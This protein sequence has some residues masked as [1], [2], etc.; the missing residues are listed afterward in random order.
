MELWLPPVILPIFGHVVILT[1]KAVE[2]SEE[3][4]VLCAQLSTQLWGWCQYLKGQG[5]LSWTIHLA[6]A[7][8]C[9][10]FG[11]LACVLLAVRTE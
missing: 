7:S 1:F 2:S 6:Q 9:V 3:A 4:F 5:S 8:G 10:C 11:A